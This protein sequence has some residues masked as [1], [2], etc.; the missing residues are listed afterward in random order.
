[1][2]S[3]LGV[4]GV[5][6][7]L[8]KDVTANPLDYVEGGPLNERRRELSAILDST[9]PDLGAFARRGGKMIVAIGTNDTLA[10]PGAQLDYYQSVI[11][12]M[13]R[14]QVDRFA[15]FF[16]M[17]QTGHGL[18]GTNYGTSG[19]GKTLPVA[20]VPNTL[21]SSCAAVRLGRA[22]RGARHVDHGDGG[23][24]EP[25]ALFVSDVS[26]VRRRAGSIGVIVSLHDAL[27]WR[28][29]AEPH[30]SW[31]QPFSCYGPDQDAHLSDVRHVRDD[32]R[33]GRRHHSRRSSGHSSCR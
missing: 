19:D 10:S 18:S 20:P 2:H 6:G 25:A 21:R 30:G 11:D 23:R 27:N 29:A 4:L 17:P 3:H 24:E 12:K 5:T 15:R 31:H 8:M 28:A 22:R 16:V 9:N 32:D 26:E 33:F 14:A 1:M 13:G 7:F